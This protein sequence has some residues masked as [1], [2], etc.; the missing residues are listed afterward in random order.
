MESILAASIPAFI[1]GLALFTVLPVWLAYSVPDKDRLGAFVLGLFTPS[2]IFII[3]FSLI[4]SV[5]FIAQSKALPL[6]EGG[7]WFTLYLYIVFGVFYYFPKIFNYVK[8]LGKL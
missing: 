5:Y 1:M 4:N 3:L 6:E 7:F 2:F 8:K